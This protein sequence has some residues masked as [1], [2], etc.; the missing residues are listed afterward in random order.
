MN[1]IE[2]LVARATKYLGS[3]EL[4]LEHGD[5]E[6]SV[7]RSYYAMFFC[8]QALLLTKSLTVSS[9]KG[10]NSLFSEHFVKTGLL[11]RE[12][13]RELN[14]A[15]EKR[16]L[17]DYEFVFVLAEDEAREI[18]DSATAFVDQCVAYL[19]DNGYL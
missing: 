18:L 10:L 19:K 17:G 11:A 7:S 1:E 5:P 15:F 6:S 14:R 3:A 16:Q 9:H 12:M 4:L 8:V 13:S 2:S